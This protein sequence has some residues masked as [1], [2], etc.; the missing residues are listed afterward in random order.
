MAVILNKAAF[1]TYVPN[2]PVTNLDLIT[3]ANIAYSGENGTEIIRIAGLLDAFN[4]SGD[5]IAFPPG[6]PW[7]GKATPQESTAIAD[8]SYWDYLKI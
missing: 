8:T 2:D 6:L 5:N 3:A 7:Q 1:N 4:N